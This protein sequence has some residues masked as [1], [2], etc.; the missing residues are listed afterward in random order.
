ME[1]KRSN[2]FR[3][4]MG[5]MENRLPMYLFAILISA[6]G[7]AGGKVANSLLVKNI[8]SAAQERKAEGLLFII[9]LNFV[10]IVVMHL[11]WRCGIIRYNIEGRRG[12]AKVEKMIFSK[13][14]RLPMSYYEK[15]HSGEFMSKLIYDTEKAKDIYSSIF[16][17]L[18]T[19]V[20]SSV[21]FLIPMFY[22][23]VELTF[24]LIGVSL[25]STT[26]NSLFLDPMKKAGKEASGQNALVTEKLT[27]LL[28]G[29]E[30]AKIFSAGEY[31]CNAY[32]KASRDYGKVL[33]KTGRLSAVLESIKTFFDLA[34]SLAFLGLGIFFISN[35]RISLGELSAMYTLYGSFR[36]VFMEIGRYLP[37]LMN[38]LSNVEMLY[39]FMMLEEEEGSDAIG[40]VDS[41]G[42]A[43]A[44]RNLSFSYEHLSGENV[45][46]ERK[47]FENL[48]LQFE[49]GI[50]TA[51]TGPS[52][53]GKSTLAKLIL[54]FYPIAEGKILFEQEV[55]ETV[56]LEK[57]RKNIAYVPQEPYLYGVSIAENIAYGKGGTYP[58][59]VPMEEI[60]KAAKIAN[61]HDFI[62]K[63]PKGYDTIPGERGN[64]LSGGEK[65]RIAIA[66]AIIKNAPILLL[67]EATSALDN[68]SER[69][70][71]EALSNICKGRTTIMIAHR[72]STISMADKVISLS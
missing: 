48:N 44:I 67:D 18:F 6:L 53:C 60:M 16:R 61:A 13:A 24:A 8:V 4:Y 59:E 58:E 20:L 36:Y 55:R 57:I 66:R 5:L 2:I 63:L 51:V 1:K 27:G 31:L 30:V 29:M 45:S 49:K 12:A 21:V 22:Y 37:Q 14:M 62:M 3:W 38:C 40:C 34:G 41:V 56:T 43:V 17:R 26:A 54:G 64:T 25:V 46:E 42:T 15:H 23:S 39:A 70:I 68:E 47:L 71:N 33:I 19:A 35:K 52:G 72:S 69:L 65:Q 32:D 50:C 28:S 9:F 10:L 7:N 11:L